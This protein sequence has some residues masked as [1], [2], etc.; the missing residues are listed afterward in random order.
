MVRIK[1]VFAQSCYR[2]V[3]MQT[4]DE[5]RE[6]RF[7]PD[8]DTRQFARRLGVAALAKSNQLGPIAFAPCVRDAFSVIANIRRDDL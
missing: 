6:L 8:C 4:R 7:H 5:R 1:V 3:T 2:L